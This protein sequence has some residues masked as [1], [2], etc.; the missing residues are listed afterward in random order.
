MAESFDSPAGPRILDPENPWLGLVSFREDDQEFFFGRAEETDE[1]LRL[2]LRERLTV[3]FGKSGMGKTSLLRAGLFPRLRQKD[4]LPVYLRLDYT[5]GAAELREQILVA[6]AREAVGA[7]VEGPAPRAGESLWEHFHRQD[8]EFWSPL[9]H[10]VTPLL[11]FDQFEEV[12]TL[13][14]RRFVGTGALIEEIA[15]L[16]E[17]RPPEE[18]KA[19]LAEDPD[20]AR[21]FSF[22]RHPRIL[23]SLREDFLPELESL[24]RLIPSLGRQR[25]RLL[26]MNGS[27]AL[28]AVLGAG[29]QVIQDDVAMRL[30]RFVAGGPDRGEPAEP[31]SLEV[32][33]S[34]LS[35]V[36]HQLNENRQRNGLQHITADLLAGDQTEEILTQFYEN[37]LADL[38]PGAR[39][40]VEDRLLT[41][42]GFRD[43]IALENALEI[44]GITTE[45][46]DRL[47]HRR[48]LRVED[49]GGVQRLE[50]THDVLTGTVRASRDRRRQIE[51]AEHGRIVGRELRPRRTVP[52]SIGL[53]LLAVALAAQAVIMQ[54][55]AGEAI[56][57]R[58]QIER[59]AAESVAKLQ[60]AEEEVDR[61]RREIE[62][63][64]E[65]RP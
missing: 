33:P 11:V 21:M 10:L 4:V 16:A 32:E 27:G 39:A 59:Q 9:N 30:I 3:L 6:V 15:E 56:S 53:L 52:L 13:G 45:T 28:Q 60:K 43:S 48:L 34:L 40:F 26:R 54:K 64:A 1:L 50:L 58:Q 7:R 2:I 37:S 22:N 5:E 25:F 36:C 65:R 62:K 42:A 20:A 46:I 8:A 29:H 57:A 31:T 55:R 47:T 24:R 12:F 49:R 44:P 63:C 41:V 17:G 23:I 14:R 51:A 38:G 18:V 19:R 61:L 35:V